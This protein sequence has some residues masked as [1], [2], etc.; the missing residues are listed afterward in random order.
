MNDDR[1][2]A[3]G[4]L[5]SGYVDDELTQQKRQFVEVHA[6]SCPQ[7]QQKLEELA[8]L[9]ARFRELDLGEVTTTEWRERM[10]EPTVANTRSIGWILLVGGI[11][12]AGAYG[13]VSFFSSDASMLG[14]LIVTGVYGGLALLLISV[15]R[16]RLIERKTDKYE[17]VEI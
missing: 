9:K 6:R 10:D 3:L 11:L 15:V 5:L 4:A 13:V 17:D 2:D 16:Q 7:C 1:C 8:A 14:K 12:L